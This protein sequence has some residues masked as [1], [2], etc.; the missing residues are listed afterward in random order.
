MQARS[1]VSTVSADAKEAMAPARSRWSWRGMVEDDAIFKWLLLVPALIF[2]VALVIYP[3][4]FAVVTSFQK[5]ILPR[6]ATFAG[7]E[8]WRWVVNDTAFWSAFLTTVKFV[9]IAVGVELVLGTLIALFLNREFRGQTV[10]RGL[11]ILPL[12]AAPFATSLAWRHLYNSDYG[13][14]NYVLQ[15]LGLPRVEFLADSSIALYSVIAIDVWQWTP[16]V[17]FVVFAAL[18]G[19]PKEPFEAAKIDGAS[20]WFTFRRL[21][22]PMIKPVLLIVAMLRMVEAFRVYDILYGTTRGGPGTSTETINWLIFR[23]GFQY[24][25]LGRATAMSV[26]VLLIVLV[27][28]NLLFQQLIKAIRAN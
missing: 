22:L 9:V 10:I 16:L 24:F 8:N 26:L 11:C 23:E 1:S 21:T 20:A 18:R 12:V 15:A 7:L 17:I 27:L 28:T 2:M 3:T 5:Y 13:V 6:P 19:L 14:I 25:D 4:V